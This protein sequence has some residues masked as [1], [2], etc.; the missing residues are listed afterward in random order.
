MSTHTDTDYERDSVRSTVGFLIWT[1]GWAA[2]LAVAR[3]GPGLWGSGLSAASWIAVAVNVLVGVGWI[4][5]FTRLLRSLDELQR[6]IMLD[7]LAVALGVGWVAGFG[8]VVAD[9]ASLVT[10]E[11][12]VAVLPA[13]MGVVFIIAFVAG[14]IRYR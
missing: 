5:A 10:P 7:A 8:Y 4:I 2:T 1:V 11:V 14:R 3:F 12:N 13:L 6:K 9:L